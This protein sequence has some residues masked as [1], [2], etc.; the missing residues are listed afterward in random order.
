LGGG[1][2]LEF[3]SEAGNIS[4]EDQAQIPF[5]SE[6]KGEGTDSQI[7]EERQVREL[8]YGI[9]VEKYFSS[10][11]T[12]T[13]GRENKNHGKKKTVKAG[14]VRFTTGEHEFHQKSIKRGEKDREL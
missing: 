14:K 4:G 9:G 11:G 10:S 5:N 1:E 7:K 8:R 2:G 13:Q 6:N 3:E 12:G